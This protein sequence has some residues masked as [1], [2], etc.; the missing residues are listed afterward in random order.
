MARCPHSREFFRHNREK[1][2]IWH[3]ALVSRLRLLS[4]LADINADVALVLTQNVY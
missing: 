2:G 3:P 1:Q 4:G